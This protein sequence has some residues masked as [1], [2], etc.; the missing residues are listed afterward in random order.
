MKVYIREGVFSSMNP[1]EDL[2]F[3][4]AVFKL[5]STYRVGSVGSRNESSAE[6]SWSCLVVADML[7]PHLNKSLNRLKVYE[8]L[9]Y[10]DLVEAECGDIPLSPFVNVEEKH[11]EEQ[12]AA[13]RLAKKLPKEVSKRFVSL[14]TEY[15]EQGS[16]EALFAKLVDGFE[17][18][19][20]TRKSD[21]DW[22]A[23]GV[24]FFDEKRKKYFDYFPEL[25]PYFVELRKQLITQGVL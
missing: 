7:F 25:M 4:D 11:A 14:W 6:H 3:L 5:K 10:H 22:S 17:S 24:E 15:E 20:F 1:K 18:D 23:W 2:A 21:L 9:I 16:D 12:A 8:F 13:A 19:A